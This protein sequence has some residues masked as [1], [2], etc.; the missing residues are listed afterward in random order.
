MMRRGILLFT[1]AIL[2]SGGLSAC[3]GKAVM[4]SLASCGEEVYSRE[5]EEGILEHYFVYVTLHDAEDGEYL[6][7]DEDGAYLLSSGQPIS[8]SYMP[9]FPNHMRLCIQQYNEEGMVI[10]DD[11]ISTESQ[12]SWVLQ[13][14]LPGQYVMRVIVKNMVIKSYILKVDK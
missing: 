9:A 3:M 13:P 6:E 14:L 5:D 4:P 12:G 1:A 8:V 10:F 2:A 11:W 7:Q